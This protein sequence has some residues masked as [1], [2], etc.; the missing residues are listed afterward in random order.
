MSSDWKCFRVKKS[1]PTKDRTS[2]KGRKKEVNNQP[3]TKMTLISKYK[4]KH[5]FDEMCKN[6]QQIP[7][8]K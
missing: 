7:S 6:L 5:E 3:V 8:N 1:R 4:S 2:L